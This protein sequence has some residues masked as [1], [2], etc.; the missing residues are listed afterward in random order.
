MQIQEEGDQWSWAWDEMN[1]EFRRLQEDG[2]RRPTAEFL[3][4]MWTAYWKCYLY[5]CWLTWNDSKRDGSV[6]HTQTRITATEEAGHSSW[7]DVTLATMGPGRRSPHWW[8]SGMDI[9]RNH[10]DQPEA[11]RNLLQTHKAALKPSYDWWEQLL[12]QKNF[13]VEL[14]KETVEYPRCNT[15]QHHLHRDERYSRDIIYIKSE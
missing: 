5:S 15:K 12:E 6:N 10:G 3:S 1:Q 7:A 8:G 9:M 13:A 11:C 4:W 2:G 14:L